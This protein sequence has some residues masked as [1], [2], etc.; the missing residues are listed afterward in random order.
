M[1]PTS[2]PSKSANLSESIHQQLSMYALAATATGVGVLAFVQ[3][4][5]AKIVYTPAHLKI[6]LNTD[7][8]LDL[9]HDG[10]H[11]FVLFNYSLQCHA[12]TCGAGVSVG[13]GKAGNEIWGQ[14]DLASALRAGV[15]IGARGH[16]NF[17]RSAG[18]MADWFSS[19][20]THGRFE[21]PWANGGKGVKNR[22]LGLKFQINGR[23]HF[24]WARLNVAWNHGFSA[25]LTGYAYETVANR[26]IITGKTKGPD[27]ISIEGQ[28]AVL[29]APNP[30]LTTL[31]AL[32]LGAPG[33]SIWR[34]NESVV[35]RPESN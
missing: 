29:T 10:I 22:Y 14:H 3:P 30:V 34:R 20:G 19:P 23:T 28:D 2:R 17:S 5:E 27:E 6:P 9:N 1:K 24:G 12:N 25:T 33:L 26:P 13:P 8:F 4:S 16:S 15:R 21:G 11:D 31:G 18:L 35:A 32:A 7:F